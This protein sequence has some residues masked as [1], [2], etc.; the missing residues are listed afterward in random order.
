MVVV[1]HQAP[2]KDGETVAID[3]IGEY[4]DESFSLFPNFKE[5]LA[6]TEPIEYVVKASLNKNAIFSW[7][8]VKS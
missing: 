8:Q 5:P 3:D 4:S 2:S 7:H 6:S 1:C